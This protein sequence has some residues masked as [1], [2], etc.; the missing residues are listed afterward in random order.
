MKALANSTEAQKP[1]FSNLVLSPN[2]VNVGQSFKI[3]VTVTI[4]RYWENELGL[5]LFPLIISE[6]SGKI[7]GKTE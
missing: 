6:D 3:S 7:F 5:P 2:H 4:D 1:V